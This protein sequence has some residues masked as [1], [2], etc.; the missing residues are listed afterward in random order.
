MLYH[1][2]GYGEYCFYNAGSF[3]LIAD[4]MISFQ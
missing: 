2:L 3:Y 1:K 4:T